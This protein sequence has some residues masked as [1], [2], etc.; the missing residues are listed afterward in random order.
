MFASFV[1]RFL[2]VDIL[3]FLIALAS[4]YGYWLF[5]SVGDNA[6]AGWYLPQTINELIQSLAFWKLLTPSFIHFNEIH[7]IS[8]VVLLWFFGRTIS[9]RSLN[10]FIGLLLSAA[11][12]SN[13]AEWAASGPLFG[14][15]SGVVSACVGFIAFD[16][17]FAK[18]R[19][20]KVESWIIIAFFVYLVVVSSGYFGLYSNAA[21]FSGAVWGILV[22]A[23]QSKLQPKE[24]KESQ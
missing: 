19:Q 21:H 22:G 13:S 16:H 15:L 6:L 4:A 5:Y 18:S 1:K 24:V 2:P 9:E 11:L 3:L 8:N 14:G 23:L 7:L 20:F 12:V 17:F 10:W